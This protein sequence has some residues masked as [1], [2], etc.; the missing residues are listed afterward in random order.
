M[1]PIDYSTD[2]KSPFEQSMGGFN[3][4]LG[5][6]ADLAKVKQAEQAAALQAQLQTDLA[7]LAQKPNAKASDYAGMM[8]KYPQLSDHFKRGWET[9]NGEQQ[10]NKLSTAT[11]VYA[12]VN[13][14]KVDIA[15]QL[16]KQS[17]AAEV[18]GEA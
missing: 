8:V 6:R 16:L 1:G 9:L 18:D 14:G 2:V 12:A 7:G 5:M 13:S 15:V 11:Q 10:H 17:I 4:A 3:A